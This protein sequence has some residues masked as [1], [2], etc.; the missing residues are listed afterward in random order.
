MCD[1]RI[2]GSLNVIIVCWY[3]AV[4]SILFLFFSSSFISLCSADN[5][6]S[7]TSS[8]YFSL[9][10][11]VGCTKATQSQIYL[12]VSHFALIFMLI[13]H[14]MMLQSES[15]GWM[16]CT[17]GVFYFFSLFF[18]SRLLF[19]VVCFILL[20]DFFLFCKYKRNKCSMCEILLVHLPVR[21]FTSS[22]ARI[23][24]T[25]AIHIVWFTAVAAVYDYACR[26][27]PNFFFFWIS[28][29]RFEIR[30][31]TTIKIDRLLI[32]WRI[33]HVFFFSLYPFS[34]IFVLNGLSPNSDFLYQTNK[35][36]EFWLGIYKSV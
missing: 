9:S 33:F 16:G 6:L 13:F 15:F 17:M 18:S 2:F 28:F 21:W 3:F 14:L 7:I 1:F 32:Q 25:N 36:I 8:M 20:F 24:H 35:L 19:A 34:H 27:Q 31:K 11:S 30:W 26:F 22:L 5:T 10:L 12:H 29:S 23:T 4:L